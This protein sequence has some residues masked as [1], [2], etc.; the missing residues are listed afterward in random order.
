MSMTCHGDYSGGSEYEQQSLEPL[1]PVDDLIRNH[2]G[3]NILRR[4]RS[5]RPVA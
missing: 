3:I 1:E 2:F 5:P 4:L